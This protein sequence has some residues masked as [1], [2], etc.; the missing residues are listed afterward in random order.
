MRQPKYKITLSGVKDC[1]YYHTKREVEK[2]FH[3]LLRSFQKDSK[4]D[5]LVCNEGW[6]KYTFHGECG[7]VDGEVYIARNI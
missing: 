2:Y 3:K 1:L 5:V 6:F 7:T 4:Y